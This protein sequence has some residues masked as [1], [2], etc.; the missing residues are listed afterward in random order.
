MK[1][2]RSPVKWSP[3]MDKQLAELWPSRSSNHIAKIMG[4]TYHSVW[5]R[6][7]VLGLS[8]GPRTV[9][10]EPSKEAWIRAATIH[11]NAARVRPSDVMA[12]RCYRAA[13]NARW[14]AWRDL[15]TT[16]PGISIAGI[17][18]I[19]GFDHTSVL[20]GLKRLEAMAA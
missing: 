15:A 17:G 4:L 5:R 19:S 12:G 18:R 10:F 6:G 20:H 11:A 7:T 16:Y 2:H 3:A 9:M 8:K 1:T 14:L 13:C